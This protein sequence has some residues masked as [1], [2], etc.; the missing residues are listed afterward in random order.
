MKKS[1]KGIFVWV[2]LYI[3]GYIPIILFIDTASAATRL[4]LI[5]CSFMIT[6]LS[7]AI[8]KYDKIYWYNGV[9]FEEAENATP[10]ARNRYTYAH[11]KIFMRFTC[12]Y[13][14]F[15]AAAV[16]LGISIWID[17]AIFSAGI[18]ASAISTMKIKL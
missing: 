2:L 16:Y 11:F 15:T 1:Y 5:Y 7:Y 3:T 17:I 10:E 18:I 14:I 12:F 13:I 4:S 9:M 6:L 8:Y